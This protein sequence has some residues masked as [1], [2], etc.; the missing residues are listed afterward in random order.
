V[1]ALTIPKRTSLGDAPEIGG[2]S[3]ARPAKV[4]TF[5]SRSR[6]KNGRDGF[7]RRIQPNGFVSTIPLRLAG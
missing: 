5:G 3:N 6:A 2:R 1:S 4:R 7:S